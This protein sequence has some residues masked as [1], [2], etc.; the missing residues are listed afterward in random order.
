MLPSHSRHVFK[1]T[2]IR[3]DRQAW[4]QAHAEVFAVF[5]VAPKRSVFDTIEGLQSRLPR[6]SLRA[7]SE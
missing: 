7:L 4:T 3:M 5:D 2:V 6:S 1:P